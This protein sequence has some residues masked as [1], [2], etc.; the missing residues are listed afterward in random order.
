MRVLIGTRDITGGA[1]DEK[2]RRLTTDLVSRPP[3]QP[4]VQVLGTFAT[5]SPR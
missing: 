5:L 4:I 1:A 3:F 2:R